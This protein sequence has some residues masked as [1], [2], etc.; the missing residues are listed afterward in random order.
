MADSKLVASLNPLMDAEE[1]VLSKPD[2]SKHRFS[3][4]TAGVQAPTI[5]AICG[6]PNDETLI[7]EGDRG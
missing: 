7:S 2:R 6:A 4:I 1:T 3:S 5:Q